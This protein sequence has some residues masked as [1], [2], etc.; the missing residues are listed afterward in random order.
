MRVTST[1]SESMSAEAFEKAATDLLKA[2]G[3]RVTIAR[4]QVIKI[5]SRGH[6]VYRAQE[7][8]TQLKEQGIKIDVVSVYRILETLM[9]SGLLYYVGQLRGYIRKEAG[10]HVIVFSES[11]DMA[12]EHP[13]G[14][15]IKGMIEDLA[16][17]E[18]LGFFQAEM[19]LKDSTL[20]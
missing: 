20:L 2:E 3:R 6:K 16:R 15:A 5:I 4:A 7:I 12:W 10:H 19:I 9:V 17:P 18:S 8:L 11:G 14:G 1:L 13:K